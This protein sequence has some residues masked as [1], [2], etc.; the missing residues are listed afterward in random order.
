MSAYTIF[1]L[2]ESRFIFFFGTGILDPATIE[3]MNKP[4][5]G[6]K[7]NVGN[8]NKA[9][10]RRYALHGSKWSTKD[11][12]FRISKYSDQMPKEE[13]EREIQRAF[14]V[15]AFILFYYILNKDLN[16][17]NFLNIGCK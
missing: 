6:V 10:R 5:C 16:L 3:M 8:A 12:T 13:V 7:D 14:D 1:I 17:P 15:M 9:R 4:R 2:Y 11:L